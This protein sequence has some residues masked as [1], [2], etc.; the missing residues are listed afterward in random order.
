MVNN[1][2]SNFAPDLELYSIKGYVEST[3]VNVELMIKTKQ[4][5]QIEYYTQIAAIWLLLFLC[6]Y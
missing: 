5:Y 1:F 2:K 3:S 6:Y 4:G